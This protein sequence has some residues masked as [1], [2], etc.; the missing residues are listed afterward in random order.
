MRA[1]NTPGL[2]AAC[3][4]LPLSTAVGPSGPTQP[5]APADCTSWYSAKKGDSASRVAS[6]QNIRL[7]TFMD[8]N[9]QL[10]GDPLA[11]WEGYDYC[12]P[13]GSKTVGPAGPKHFVS[14]ISEKVFGI[15]DSI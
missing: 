14:F 11:L 13:L 10:S 6:S 15:A 3:I 12:I 1:Q 2:L 7:E 8:A 4:I 5:G 9:P